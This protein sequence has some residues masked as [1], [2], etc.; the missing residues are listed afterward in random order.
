MKYF[1]IFLISLLTLFATSLHAESGKTL[2]EAFALSME[3]NTCTFQSGEDYTCPRIFSYT[4]T[5]RGLLALEGESSDVTF[6]VIDVDSTEL[7][8]AHSMSS[9]IIPLMK[10]QMI[11]V[12]VSPNMT[13]ADDLEARFYASF[14]ANDNACRGRSEDDPIVLE[15]G[16]QAITSNSRAGFGEFTS[17]LTYT[18]TETGALDISC[19]QYVLSGRYGSQFS[20]MNGVFSA[21]Y[22]NGSYRA[23]IPVTEG[24]TVC[25]SISAYSPMAILAKMS[26]PDRGSS[27]NYPLEAVEGANEVSADFGEFWYIY[28]NSG[29]EGYVTITSTYSLPRGHVSIY[30]SNDLYTPVA[31]STTGN[32]NV[33]FKAGAHSSY[34]IY[35]FKTEESDNWPEPDTFEL[36]FRPLQQGESAGNPTPLHSGEPQQLG[37]LNGIWYYLIQVP[38]DA[39]SQMIDIQTTGEGSNACQLALYDVQEGQYYSVYGSTHVQKEAKAGHSYML[40]VEKGSQGE[41]TL[42]PQIRDIL[43]GESMNLPIVAVQGE[44]HLAKAMEVYYQYTAT[45]NGRITLGVDIPGVVITFP[46][47]SNT[48]DGTYAAIQEGDKTR[49]DVEKGKTYNIRF[50]N[51][52]NDCVFTLVEN[53]YLEGETLDLAIPVSGNKITLSTGQIN[54][55]FRYVAEKAGKLTITS[56]I[57]GD[58]NT[59]IFYCR[60]SEPNMPYAINGSNEDGDIIYHG[61]IGVSADEVIYVHLVSDVDRT[62]NAISFTLTDYGQGETLATAFVLDPDGRTLDIPVASRVWNQWIRVPLNGAK[63]VKI[64]TDR[65]VAGGVYVGEHVQGEFDIPFTADENNEVHTAIYESAEPVENLYICIT[66]SYGKITLKAES[67]TPVIDGITTAGTT[68]PEEIYSLGGTRRQQPAKGVNIIRKADGRVRKVLK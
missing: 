52:T 2:S 42:M 35:V 7:S 9:T 40:V 44:N 48:Y 6:M 33:R 21:A 16:R 51:V 37:T 14:Q 29:A 57:I 46:V 28:A 59:S 43:P 38:V 17:Y 49:L 68:T 54:V 25:I 34:L 60:A 66:F 5:E 67:F 18:A 19:S 13:L 55:W 31:Q 41:V 30:A 22:D 64:T 56:N 53:E 8:Y 24:E 26:F 45:L 3:T 27:A 23:S 10:G 63:G 15:E 1:P 62:G 12:V 39:V 58:P 50:T 47:S 4:A 20:Q 65:F 11:Y 32:Y 36:G 61:A